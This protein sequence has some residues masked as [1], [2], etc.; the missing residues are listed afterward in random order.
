M[1]RA[2]ALYANRDF[3]KFSLV[4]FSDDYKTF[5][6]QIQKLYPG[7]ALDERFRVTPMPTT[8]TLNLKQI[9][10]LMKNKDSLSEHLAW[11]EGGSKYLDG[12]DI[13]SE[14]VCLTS[15]HRSGNTFMRK[16]LEAI[17]GI[18]TGADTS[19]DVSLSLSC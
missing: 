5:S 11:F 1:Y 7:Y 15:Y 8:P 18:A 12:E 16:Y 19:L 3:S 4:K 14:K 9:L 17:T 6:E 2:D 13:G 10:A